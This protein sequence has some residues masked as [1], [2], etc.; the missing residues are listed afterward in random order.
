MPI[1]I[2]VLLIALFAAPVKTL[3]QSSF[4]QAAI[5]QLQCLAPPN[6]LPLLEMLDAMGK[7][8][9]ENMTSMDSIS[10]FEIS[11]GIAISGMMFQSVCAFESDPTQRA[12]RPDLLVRA[13]GTPPV[14]QISFGTGENLAALTKWYEIAIGPKHVTRAF[15]TADNTIDGKNHVTCTGWFP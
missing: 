6:P 7:I 2:L 10:C 4:E 5:I 1:R 9:P 12:K 13:A 3:A 8:D 14:Q 15:E 11:G